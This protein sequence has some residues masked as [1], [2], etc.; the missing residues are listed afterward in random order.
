MMDSM[1]AVKRLP[2]DA[3]GV[4]WRFF[5]YLICRVCGFWAFG[6]IFVLKPYMRPYPTL[7]MAVVNRVWPRM[8]PKNQTG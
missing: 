5:A 6:T 7:P 2:E 8:R 1:R 4:G 3:G